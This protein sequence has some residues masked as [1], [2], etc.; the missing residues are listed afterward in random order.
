MRKLIYCVNRNKLLPYADAKSIK[1]TAY[2]RKDVKEAHRSRIRQEIG[3]ADRQD[4]LKEGPLVR[5]GNGRIGGHSEALV[6]QNE[7]RPYVEPVWQTIE[8]PNPPGILW[9][10]KDPM[11][12][13]SP[14]QPWGTEELFPGQYC[15]VHRK[16]FCFCVRSKC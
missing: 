11:P 3:E 2:L 1:R 9:N 16:E 10:W 13:A 5:S 15:A 14:L 8:V 6:L 12:L 4:S 7:E